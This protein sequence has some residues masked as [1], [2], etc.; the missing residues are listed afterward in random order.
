MI[1]FFNSYIERK[2]LMMM[3][4]P[5]WIF[6]VLIIL[7]CFAV[8]METFADSEDFK[9]SGTIDVPDSV[10]SLPIVTD[11]SITLFMGGPGGAP[12]PVMLTPSTILKAEEA[13][14]PPELRDGDRVKVKGNVVGGSMVLTRLDLEDFEEVKLAGAVVELDGVLT[15]PVSSDTPIQ[16]AVGGAL[17]PVLTIIL[18]PDTRLEI[19]EDGGLLLLHNS[20][21]VEI[22]V[23]LQ[24]GDLIAREIEIEEFGESKIRGTVTGLSSPLSLPVSTDTSVT[25]FI[26]SLDTITLNIVIT[27]E[28]VLKGGLT[29]L[30]NGDQVEVETIAGGAMLRAT[31]LESEGGDDDGDGDDD[32][33][34]GDDDDD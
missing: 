31:E 25:I 11:V 10:L 32:E 12:V 7:S 19:E 13:D 33:D 15:L 17:G 20:D 18:T 4:K 8:N 5:I 29:S 6:T 2:M 9:L 30:I 16:L 22:E 21:F 34:G 27:P 14:Q 3:K 1:S 24:G 28:T 23:V 26:G